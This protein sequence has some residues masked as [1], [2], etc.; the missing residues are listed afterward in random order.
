MIY[1]SSHNA[2]AKKTNPFVTL[3]WSSDLFT[4]EDIPMEN[5]FPGKIVIMNLIFSPPLFKSLD[6]SKILFN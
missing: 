4:V 6:I 5:L 1:H 2:F 3:K